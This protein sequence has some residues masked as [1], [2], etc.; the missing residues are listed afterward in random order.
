MEV[1]GQCHAWLLYPPGKSR[2]PLNWR[3]GGSQRWPGLVRKISPPPGFNPW[4]IQPAASHYTDCQAH[5]CINKL[6]RDMFLLMLQMG[7]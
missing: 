2:Y 7:R 5:T 3:L 6:Q 1:G 4:I